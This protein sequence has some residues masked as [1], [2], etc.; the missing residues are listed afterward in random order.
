VRIGARRAEP[1]ELLGAGMPPIGRTRD[2]LLADAAA[3]HVEGGRREAEIAIS[4]GDFPVWRMP[5]SGAQPNVAVSRAVVGTAEIAISAGDF[6]MRPLPVSGA[7]PN[8]AVS[9]PGWAA[10]CRSALVGGPRCCSSQDARSPAA[11]AQGSRGGRL[12]LCGNQTGRAPRACPADHDGLRRA[13]LPPR[14]AVRAAE[15]N[16]VSDRPAPLRR[17]T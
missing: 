12:L 2:G 11:A 15:Y 7:H 9:M 1:R 16:A 17:E 6:R 8:A 5:A 14:G 4:A 3:R 13:R 10:S